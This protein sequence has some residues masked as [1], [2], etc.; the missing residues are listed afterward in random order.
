MDGWD[1]MDRVISVLFVPVIPDDVVVK[2][3]M[4]CEI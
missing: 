3:R 1:V 4:P 2:T